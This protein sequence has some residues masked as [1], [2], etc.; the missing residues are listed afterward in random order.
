MITAEL[1]ALLNKSI[2]MLFNLSHTIIYAIYSDFK[3]KIIRKK[4][5]KN[6]FANKKIL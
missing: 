3:L 6:Y 1:T 5:H 4:I 2:E